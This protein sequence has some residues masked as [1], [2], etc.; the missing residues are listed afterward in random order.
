METARD[1]NINKSERFKTRNYLN[2]HDM[3]R[4]PVPF[5]KSNKLRARSMAN[6][7]EEKQLSSEQKKNC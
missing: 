5:W 7:G 3:Q 2:M 1:G 6:G 4:S